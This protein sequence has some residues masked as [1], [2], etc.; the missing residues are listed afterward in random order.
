MAL[1]RSR[2]KTVRTKVRLDVVADTRVTLLAWVEE[3]IEKRENEIRLTRD[4]R[5]ITKLRYEFEELSHRL[6]ELLPQISLPSID[7][8]G[9][10]LLE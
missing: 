4:E 10:D 5:E 7:P 8:L 3:L 1:I 2:L 9:Q 6:D